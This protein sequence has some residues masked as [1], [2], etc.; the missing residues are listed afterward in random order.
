M[1]L[2]GRDRYHSHPRDRA[3][4]ILQELCGDPLLLSQVILLYAGRFVAGFPPPV[5]SCQDGQGDRPAHVPAWDALQPRILRYAD[6][7]QAFEE[8]LQGDRGFQAGE[9]RPETEVNAPAER[10][11]P[12]R[13]AT[14]RSRVGVY[15]R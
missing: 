3:E 8:V 4:K 6:V 1:L 10:Q 5:R 14:F 13:A 9:R 15:L 7:G 11:V 2:F 12:V